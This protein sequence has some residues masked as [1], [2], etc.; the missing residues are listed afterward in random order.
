MIYRHSIRLK[1][2]QDVILLNL[3]ILN[4]GQK[5]SYLICLLK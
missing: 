5:V 3:G 4:S 2:V 1:C